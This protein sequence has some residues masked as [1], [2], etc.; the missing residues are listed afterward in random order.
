MNPRT[1]VGLTLAVA[2]AVPRAVPAAEMPYGWFKAGNQPSQ[3]EMGLDATIR[4]DGRASAFIRSNTAA[5]TGFGTLMQT[6][7]ASDYKGKRVRFSGW[8]KSEKVGDLPGTHEPGWAGLWLRADA[9]ATSGRRSDSV[10]FD[11]MQNRAI[12]GTNDWKSYEIVL[13][14]PSETAALAFGLLL[15]GDGQVWMDTLK[16]EVVGTEVAVTA[17]AK[18]PLQPPQNLAFDAPMVPRGVLRTIMSAQAGYKQKNPDTGYACDFATLVASRFLS[19]SRPWSEAQDGFRY[20]IECANKD[21]PQSSYRAAAVPVSGTGTTV[22]CAT[23]AAQ[24]LKAE[25]TAAACFE[26]GTPADK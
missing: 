12:K 22:Y 26:K 14:I 3:Y 5:L 18:A 2:V 4:H 15:A 21:K 1:R 7:D 9:P 17:P 20:T 24:L 11:N 13:D 23:E 6:A 8:V 19:D 16:F 10:A 25:G